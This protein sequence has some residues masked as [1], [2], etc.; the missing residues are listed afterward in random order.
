MT[1]WEEAN[2]LSRAAEE[3][4]NKKD[5]TKCWTDNREVRSVAEKKNMAL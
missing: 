2:M 4:E 5:E 3:T 1:S